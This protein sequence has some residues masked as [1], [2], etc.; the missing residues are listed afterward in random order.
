MQILIADPD[1]ELVT[2]LSYWLRSHG[3]IPL[4]AQDASDLL[5]L[6]RERSPERVLLDFALRGVKGSPFCQRLRQEGKGLIM[7]LT[8]PR[9]E[10]AE[11]RA[12]EQGA[13]DY[14]ARLISLHMFQA[15]LNAFLRRAGQ[16]LPAS[17]DSHFRIGSTLLNLE[18]SEVIRLGR[19]LYLKPI[20]GR[21]LQLLFANAG[22]FLPADIILQR[23]WGHEDHHANL[24]KLYIYHLRQEIEPDPG[25]PRF[26]LTLPGVGY[27]LHLEDHTPPDASS[28]A[29]EASVHS[30]TFATACARIANE[31]YNV[32]TPFS[33]PE[34]VS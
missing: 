22:Q 24:L 32:I 1:R 31:Q 19:H 2:S 33:R 6:W 17:G 5:T 16:G 8:T 15:R 25:K 12:L 18:R 27:V 13:D 30:A 21:L 14:L 20:E 26:L 34:R 3:H 28:P 7:V 9:Q 29:A 10:E 23:I 11:A 4:L